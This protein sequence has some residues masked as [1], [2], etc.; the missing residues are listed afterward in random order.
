MFLIC[1][2]TKLKILVS[3]FALQQ[4]KFINAVRAQEHVADKHIIEGTCKTQWYTLCM[5]AIL[6]LGSIGFFIFNGRNLK[7]FKGHLFSNAVKVLLFIF[8]V[9]FYVPLNYIEQLV[10]YNY[11]KHEIPKP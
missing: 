2:H 3:T 8:D 6:L 7:S 10:V 5:L 4:I 11:S 1:K 9:Q